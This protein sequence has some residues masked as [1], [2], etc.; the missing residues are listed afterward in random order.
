MMWSNHQE[1]ENLNRGAFIHGTGPA[2]LAPASRDVE[3]IVMMLD[4]TAISR[5]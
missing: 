2:G 4:A 1:G 3:G 5:P